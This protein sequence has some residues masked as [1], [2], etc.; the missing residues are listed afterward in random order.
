MVNP[1]SLTLDEKI[2]LAAF[3]LSNGNINH[4][5]TA[6]DLLIEAWKNDK[7]AFGLRGY[8]NEYPDS[9]NLYTKLM[10]KTGFVSKGYLKK[11]SNKTY[12]MTEAG[13]SIASSLEP[14]GIETNI[15]IVRYL[16]EFIVKKIN[17]PIFRE[18]LIG[19]DKPKNFRDAMWFWEIAPGTPPKTVVN[20]ITVIEQNLQEALRKSSEEG[21][22]IILEARELDK[23]TKDSLI[24]QGHSTLD[25]SRGR[26]YLDKS[27]IQK[28]IEFHQSLKSKFKKD[29][30]SMLKKDE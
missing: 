3:R 23:Q 6:E 21:G 8:E 15:K 9:N 11:V 17:H 4:T 16:Y 28:C 27:D 25:E 18:W 24:K 1:Q 2:F 14:V 29:L 30:E 13:L 19:K 12:T 20:R 5:F 7:S 22:K 10:G 26:F